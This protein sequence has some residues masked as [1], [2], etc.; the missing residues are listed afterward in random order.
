METFKPYLQNGFMVHAECDLPGLTSRVVSKVDVS[1]L[2]VSHVIKDELT[3]NMSYPEMGDYRVQNGSM[4]YMSRNEGDLTIY[5]KRHR[6][7]LELWGMLA[8]VD[9]AT[10]DEIA[11]MWADNYET[12][13]REG[14]R[15]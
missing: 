10:N 3:T 11:E 2:I 15:S 6:W 14:E 5:L 1:G 7:A 12:Y 9:G 13:P 4:I 8:H